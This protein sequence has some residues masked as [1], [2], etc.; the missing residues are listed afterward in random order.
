MVDPDPSVSN[1]TCFYALGFFSHYK[2]IP[3][4][5][6]ALGHIHCCQAGDHCLEEN[7]CYNDRYGTTYLTG[8]TDPDYKDASCPDKKS[9]SEYPWA[10]L[11]YCKFNRW[12][13]CEEAGRPAFVKTGDECDCPSDS[14]SMTV[15]FSAASII[16]G[17]G[18]LPATSGGTIEWSSGHL[19]TATPSPTTTDSDPNPN[20]P[21]STTLPSGITLPL[22]TSPSTDQPNNNTSSGLS[23]GAKAGIGTG[24]AVGAILLLGA[25]SALWL[26]FRRRRRRGNGGKNNNNNTGQVDTT[27]SGA[28]TGVG[29]GLGPGPVLLLPQTPG[30]DKLPAA[31]MP[32]P[33]VPPRPAFSELPGGGGA[34][35]P[36]VVRPELLG[37][38]SPPGSPPG[39]V[40]SG[41]WEGQGG[42]AAAPGGL[43][44]HHGQQVYQNMVQGEGHGQQAYHAAQSEGD[45]QQAYYMAQNEEQGRWVPAPEGSRTGQGGVLELPA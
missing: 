17:V 32:T 38:V 36:W 10:G 15:A 40:G 23:T 42:G 21:P 44:E 29:P 34:G 31:E 30:V 37:D 14:E 16:P 5:N 26:V 45:S 3:C 35:G 24:A 18:V 22:P 19:P 28:E 41:G 27:L 7:A 43:G 8:C 2:F 9:Y 1:G 4:G 39:T 11:V 12:M 33:E 6:A 25:L 20:P 13:A